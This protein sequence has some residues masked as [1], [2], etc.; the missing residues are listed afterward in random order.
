MPVFFFPYY[1]RAYRLY[2]IYNA[3]LE[4]YDLKIKKGAVMGFKKTRSLHF[5][6]EKNMLKWLLVIMIPMFIATIFAVLV[7]QFRLWFPSF[8]VKTCFLGT[9]YFIVGPDVIDQ[10]F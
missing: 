8:E 5:V 1:M 7:P 6:R 9:D 10:R 3:H 4:H 2:L